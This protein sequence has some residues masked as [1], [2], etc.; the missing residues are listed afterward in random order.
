MQQLEAWKSGVWPKVFERVVAC[1]DRDAIRKLRRAIP[2][3]GTTRI[4]PPSRMSLPPELS[5]E[6]TPKLAPELAPELS[7]E[8]PPE[9]PPELS[10]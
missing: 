9:L 10:S 1:G 3:T 6:I 4:L 2:M 8:L 7:P 5:P